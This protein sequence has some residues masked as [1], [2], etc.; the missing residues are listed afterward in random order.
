M[1]YMLML[2]ADDK[3]GAL[4]RWVLLRQED[5]DL[6]HLRLDLLSTIIPNGREAERPQV[7][8]TVGNVVAD[9][10]D[11]RQCGRFEKVLLPLPALVLGLPPVDKVVLVFHS[12]A[13]ILLTMWSLYYSHHEL[14]SLLGSEV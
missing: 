13:L 7:R 9:L 6:V 12:L 1:R 11:P 8:I 2:Y 4:E 5:G 14:S 10:G 3:A